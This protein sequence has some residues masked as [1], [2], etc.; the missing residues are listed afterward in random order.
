[1]FDTS[2]SHETA[3]EEDDVAQLFVALL[4]ASSFHS[5]SCCFADGLELMC[6][7]IMS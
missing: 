6:M 5:T 3:I 2:Q 7:V 4:T 1:M